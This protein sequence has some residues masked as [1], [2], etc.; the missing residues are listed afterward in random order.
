MAHPVKAG[1]ERNPAPRR[2]DLMDYNAQRRGRAVLIL[3]PEGRFLSARSLSSCQI[4]VFWFK[5]P[6]ME[7]EIDCKLQSNSR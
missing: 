4:A 6:S 2:C 7:A 5:L 3:R 1:S